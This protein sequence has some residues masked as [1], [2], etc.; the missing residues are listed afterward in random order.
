MT[1][2]I[3]VAEG[4]AR[5]YDGRIALTDC[6]F[7]LSAG[8]VLGLAGPNGAG[9]STLA[10]L[11][12][13]FVQPS[14]GTIRLGALT[15][16]QYRTRHGVGYLPEDVAFYAE[17]T[18]YEL[19]NMRAAAGPLDWRRAADLLD[20]GPLLH[21]PLRILSKGQGRLAYT[22]YAAL[23]PSRVV[24]LDE[25]DSGLDPTALDR[26]RELVRACAAGGAVVVVLSHQLPEL[27]EVCDRVMFLREGRVSGTFSQDEVA[28]RGARSLYRELCA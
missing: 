19:L 24:V 23:G 4:L 16:A 28:S 13:G 20:L 15:P 1:S 12:T 22:A 6:S 3:C 21:R 11:L 10:R 26:L 2:P 17:C 14:A 27:A 18:P 8:E 7:Q 9:K 5:S 25:P